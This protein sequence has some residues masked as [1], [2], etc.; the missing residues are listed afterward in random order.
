MCKYSISKMHA[1]QTMYAV[2]SYLL[3]LLVGKIIYPK[4]QCNVLIKRKDKTSVKFCKCNPNTICKN[5]RNLKRIIGL[6]SFLM[7]PEEICAFFWCK[8]TSAPLGRNTKRLFYPRV[9]TFHR[10]ISKTYSTNR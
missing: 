5:E 2:S 4:R 1:Q 8:T 3:Y 9:H 10:S 6:Y 7:L